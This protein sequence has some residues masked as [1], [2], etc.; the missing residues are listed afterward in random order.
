MRRPSILAQLKAGT[1]DHS[2]TREALCQQFP[3]I[4]ALLIAAELT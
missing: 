3:V 1:A 4:A 2:V